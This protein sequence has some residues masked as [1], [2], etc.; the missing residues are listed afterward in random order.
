[1]V[2]KINFINEELK[3]RRTDRFSKH[4]ILFLFKIFIFYN[5][6]EDINILC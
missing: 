1:M 3:A 4:L 2:R 5:N 6:K